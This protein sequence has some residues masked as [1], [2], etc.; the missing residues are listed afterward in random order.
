MNMP[1]RQRQRALDHAAQSLL[2]NRN[3]QSFDE[4]TILTNVGHTHNK[5]GEFEMALA[6]Y[7]EALNLWKALGDKR[8]EAITLKHMSSALRDQGKLVEAQT[9]IEKSL[10]LLE[11]MREH[12]GTPELQSSF[13]AGLFDFYE[14]Y[15][16]LLMR[17]HAAGPKAGSDLAALAF[18]EKVKLRSLKELL[19]QA[20]VDLRE[21]VD[22]AL[23][24]RE[25]TINKLIT[26]RLD[27]QTKLLRGKYTDE[28]SDAAERELGE[29]KDKYRECRRKFVAPHLAA[30]S[31]PQPLTV[32]EIQRRYWTETI[33]LEYALGSE[34]SYLWGGDLG[35]RAESSIAAKATI[36]TQAR[37]I[38]QL[39]M[40]R[41]PALGLTL[42][43]QRAREQAA[44]A[45]Y[46]TQVNIL[47]NMLLEPVAGRLGTKRLVI[48]ADGALQYLPFAVLPVPETLATAKTSLA[49]PLIID[50][51]IVSLPSASVL[52][53]LRRELAGRG[54]A[55]RMVAV[56]ADPV[57][58]PDDERVS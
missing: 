27:E 38:Y 26:A 37:R 52:A 25:R 29:L 10:A 46:Q 55:A 16:D 31:E 30:L 42:A 33:L 43:Q 49:R 6:K 21:G 32:S 12:A 8:G 22:G 13:V 41:Q 40:A 5:R 14:Y 53:V 56:L 44:D 9:N 48:V 2:L 11:F 17:I 47:S 36:E 19:I 50:H 18:T 34:R 15:V 1:R 7:S 51:E 20:G 4:A 3:L 24:D 39:L 23:V 35:W 57:F 54:R 45:E 28:Q 58:E